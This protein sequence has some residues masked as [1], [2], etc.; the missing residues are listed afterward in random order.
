MLDTQTA[1]SQ[2]CQT[3]EAEASSQLQHEQVKLTEMQERIELLDKTLEKASG[4]HQ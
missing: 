1:E 4:P 2:A 3:S